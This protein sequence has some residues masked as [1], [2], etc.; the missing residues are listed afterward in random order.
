MAIT[1][2]KLY[3]DTSGFKFVEG[4]KIAMN[5][6]STGTIP[7]GLKRIDNITVVNASSAT[8]VRA[9]PNSNNGTADSLNGTVYIADATTTDVLYVEVKGI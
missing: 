1:V 5:S 2:T 7:T 3:R 6:A 9:M 8:A 4:Y